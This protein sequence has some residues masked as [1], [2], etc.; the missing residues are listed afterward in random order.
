L[1]ALVAFAE[2]QLRAEP[3]QHAVSSPT[4]PSSPSLQAHEALATPSIS[5]EDNMAQDHPPGQM[6]AIREVDRHDIQLYMHQGETFSEQQQELQ[7]TPCAAVIASPATTAVTPTPQ[8]SVMASE[9]HQVCDLGAPINL[10]LVRVELFPAS[11]ISPCRE[12]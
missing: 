11:S 4:A 10:S 1:E 6:L 9:E 8:W 5:P 2:A 3:Q 12:S 7:L